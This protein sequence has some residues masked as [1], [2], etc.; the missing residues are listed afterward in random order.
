VA[1][2]RTE[3]LLNLVFCLMA[4]RRAVPRSFIRANVTGYDGSA[5]DDAFER[6][7]ER[8]KD[9][10]RAMGIP[11]ET[12][13]SGAEVEGYRITH[14]DYALDD[15][16]FSPSELSVLAVAAQ[17]WETAA[18]QPAAATALRKI[19]ALDGNE[20]AG[21]LLIGVTGTSALSMPAIVPLLR[22][23][24][25]RQ[26]VRFDYRKPDASQT[27]TRKVE[28][29]ALVAWRGAWYLVGLDVDRT[30]QRVFRLS[31]IDGTVTAWGPDDA[32]SIP[33]DKDPRSAV[34]DWIGDSSS[35]TVHVQVS[36]G[37]G[38]SLRLR[39]SLAGDVVSVTCADGLDVVPEI[40][41]A[42][43][44]AIVIEP[45]DVREVVMQRLQTLIA[46]HTR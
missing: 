6:M 17:V 4:S 23:I 5:S 36:P 37:A 30:S 14:E 40:L 20:G 42:G 21:S 24:R 13:M 35:R 31:R 18:R 28:P 10:L 26:R 44:D 3:R 19:E 43:P 34:G 39:G 38:A 45:R 33:R 11:I 2:D 41:S 9:E 16:R 12:V 22:A 7:F 29:W 27:E 15:L 8:D 32:F 1:V 46:G 25:R